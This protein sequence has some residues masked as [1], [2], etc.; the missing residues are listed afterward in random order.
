MVSFLLLSLLSGV[1]ELGSVFLGIRLGASVAEIIL[2]PFW[3]QMG[4]FLMNYLPR[5]KTFYFILFV[6]FA[7]ET[8]SNSFSWSYIVF[9]SQ[10]VIAS[11]CIQAAREKNK[12]S[13]P[14]WLKRAFR[15]GGFA[16]SPI[17][18]LYNG[19]PILI[20]STLFSVMFLLRG[21]ATVETTSNKKK[22]FGIS[23]VMVFH[24]IHYF[25]YTYIMPIYL[26]QRTGSFI[27]VAISFVFTWIVYLF[28]QTIV[29]K[30]DIMKY[31]TVFF[32]GHSFLATCLGLMTWMANARFTKGVLFCW[33]LTGFGGGTV[34]CIKHLSSRYEQ[35]NMDLSE[36][37]GHV[38]GP[39]L[40]ILI[41]FYAPEIETTA[42]SLAACTSVI[43]TLLIAIIVV[44]KEKIKFET[45]K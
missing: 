29:E 5:N 7:S 6:T 10:L 19:Q 40:A 12:K 8:I 23:L 27:I 11:Y 4:N 28:P 30:Y 31:K 22:Y 3:Y 45:N 36:N 34:F 14:T 41:C 42:L 2:L 25:V 43:A 15:I 1:I 38:M 16:I 44:A 39:A 17:L 20:A 26:Y 33:L 9:T 18:V 35:I 21:A 32:V 13:C 37:I 24:Q